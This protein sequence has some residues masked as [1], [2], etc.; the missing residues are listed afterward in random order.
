LERM[1]ADMR[2]A[3]LVDVRERNLLAAAAVEDRILDL[4]GQLLE[5]TVE[6][7][8]VMLRQALQHREIELVAAIP[9]LDRAAAE[10]HVR[11]RDDALRIEILDDAEPVAFGTRAHRVVEREQPRLELL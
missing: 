5:R 1:L 11:K 8:P 10:A 3:P 4:L 2:A 7:E 9:A 6:I